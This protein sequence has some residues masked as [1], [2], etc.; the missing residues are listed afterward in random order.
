MVGMEKTSTRSWDP[1]CPE[2]G[3]GT[4]YFQSLPVLPFGYRNE[5]ETTREEW[6][7]WRRECGVVLK[8]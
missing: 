6:I 4:G 8:E 2:H 7:Q 3:V 5:R 1:D